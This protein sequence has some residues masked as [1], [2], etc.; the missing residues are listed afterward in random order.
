M[1]LRSRLQEG[2][3]IGIYRA[4]SGFVQESYSRFSGLPLL[5]LIEHEGINRHTKYIVRQPW[6]H[7]SS[8]L[9][10]LKAP[11]QHLV[12]YKP[13]TLIDDLF[14]RTL[15]MANSV[16]GLPSDATDAKWKELYDGKMLFPLAAKYEC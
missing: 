1:N 14:D 13:T 2:I 3:C 6:S 11:V 9:T 10:S 16:D 15:Y 5:L 7:L 8:F 12:A 4:S